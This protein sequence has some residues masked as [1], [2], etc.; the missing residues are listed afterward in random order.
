MPA[1]RPRCYPRRGGRAIED[2]RSVEAA[3]SGLPPFLAADRSKDT[4]VTIITTVAGAATDA[5]KS[6]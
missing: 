6:I 3:P 5:G 4:G 1:M 2:C